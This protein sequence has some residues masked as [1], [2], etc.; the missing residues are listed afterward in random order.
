MAY[1]GSSPGRE[2]TKRPYATKG[3]T[4][5][6][7]GCVAF[8][9]VRAV[10]RTSAPVGRSWPKHRRTHEVPS[11]EKSR[12]ISEQFVKPK[13]LLLSEA[14]GAIPLGMDLT[15]REGND[16]MVTF[17]FSYNPDRVCSRCRAVSRPLRWDLWV[18]SRVVLITRGARAWEH[19]CLWLS[20]IGSWL[21]RPSP[22]CG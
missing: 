21:S 15:Q 10:S 19:T 5:Q 13:R 11:Q 18:S 4:V 22:R 7:S 14:A 9:C 16:Y 2:K 20:A 12:I 3:S 6:P 17:K 8:M 1:P